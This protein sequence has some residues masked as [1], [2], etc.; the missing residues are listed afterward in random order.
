MKAYL[1]SIGEATTQICKDQLERFGFEVVL[2]DGKEPW[3]DKY[4]KFIEIGSEAYENCIR[5]DADVIPNAG[6]KAVFDDI[7]YWEN[8][9]S[10]GP[11]LM[12]QWNCY[13]FYRNGV[14][15]CSPVYYSKEALLIIRED[16]SELDKRRPEATAWRIKRINEYTQT[17]NA[18]VGMHGFFQDKGHLDRHLEN[19]IERKQMEEY[20]F[21]LAQ[22][23]LK[24]TS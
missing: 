1:T 19:K 13:D 20:D 17:G 6:I 2:L 18:I 23:L 24:I 12:A 11:V 9:L 14:G 4:R 10:N 21:D 3:I 16:W 7:P 22:R 8:I 5:I 15:V